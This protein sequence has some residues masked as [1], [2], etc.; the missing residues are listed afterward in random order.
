MHVC[1]IYR[2]KEYQLINNECWDYYFSTFLCVTGNNKSTF[3]PSSLIWLRYRCS[4][5]SGFSS[6]FLTLSR[7]S[8][9]PITLY[10]GGQR[11]GGLTNFPGHE[12]LFFT[13]RLKDLLIGSYQ[14]LEVL[15]LNSWTVC[16]AILRDIAIPRSNLGF[17]FMRKA[18]DPL[19]L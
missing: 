6:W 5:M 4:C 17:L 1:K 13:V 11:Y 3:C 8:E 19:N 18:L 15:A 7:L 2:T 9:P 12:N 16:V 14:E 10:S